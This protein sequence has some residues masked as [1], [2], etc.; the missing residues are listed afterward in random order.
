[1]ITIEKF[2]LFWRDRP[3]LRLE[4][5]LCILYGAQR[6]KLLNSLLDPAQ[7]ARINRTAT[8][9][10][11]FKNRIAKRGRDYLGNFLSSY[12]LISI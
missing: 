11:K 7:S 2:Y 10:L 9:S 12:F 8:V 4:L 1:M 3:C 6:S 5:K